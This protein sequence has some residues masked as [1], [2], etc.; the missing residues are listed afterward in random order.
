MLCNAL[1]VLA[2]II[3]VIEAQLV[4]RG[5]TPLGD[6]RPVGFAGSLEHQTTNVTLQL[7]F[8]SFCETTFALLGLNLDG[9]RLL[10]F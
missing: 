10:L 6:L 8:E 9:H 2:S 4:E 1:Q 5:L 3:I 7:T